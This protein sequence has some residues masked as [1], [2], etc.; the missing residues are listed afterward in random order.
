MYV[1][2]HG[3]ILNS[4][5]AFFHLHTWFFLSRVSTPTGYKCL[6]VVYAFFSWESRATNLALYP[7]IFPST[8]W[9]NY[10]LS[11]MYRY[12]ILD[13][14]LLELVF[15]FFLE[16]STS[17]MLLHSSYYSLSWTVVTCSLEQVSSFFS[18]MRLYAIFPTSKMHQLYD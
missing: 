2:S 13:I 7:T 14:I 16:G 1:L 18:C 10:E 12:C 11:F 15:P 8:A 5:R 3:C 4:Y 6:F 17:M 9:W